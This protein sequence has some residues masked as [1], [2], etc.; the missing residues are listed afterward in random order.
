MNRFALWLSHLV[1]RH[2]DPYLNNRIDGIWNQIHSDQ[3]D[4]AIDSE[5]VRAGLQT[6]IDNLSARISKGGTVT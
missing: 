1:Y 2:P 5:R 3:N 6:Q 4:L